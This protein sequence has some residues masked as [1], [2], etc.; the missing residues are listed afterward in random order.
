MAVA[1][2]K[3]CRRPVRWAALGGSSV[4]FEQAMAGVGPYEIYLAHGTY[5]ARKHPGIGHPN[6]VAYQRH[7][8]NRGGGQR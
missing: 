2:C 1:T 7:I 3:G 8:C 4:P 5:R 6:V